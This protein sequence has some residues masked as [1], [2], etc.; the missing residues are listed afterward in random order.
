MLIV[1]C[2]MTTIGAL[3]FDPSTVSDALKSL[4]GIASPYIPTGGRR[5]DDPPDRPVG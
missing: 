5:R 1:G 4:A 2:S 3:I